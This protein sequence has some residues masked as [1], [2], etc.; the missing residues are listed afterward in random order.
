LHLAKAQV[1]RHPP[2]CKTSCTTRRHYHQ[3]IKPFTVADATPEIVNA[4]GGIN[5]ATGNKVKNS[6][7]H[8][9]FMVPNPHTTSPGVLSQGNMGFSSMVRRY[10]SPRK[11]I[12]S[13]FSKAIT[14]KASNPK[15]QSG[16]VLSP[17]PA[18]MLDTTKLAECDEIIKKNP[19]DY[20]SHNKKGILLHSL[21]SFNEAI[22]CFDEAITLAPSRPEPYINKATSLRDLGQFQLSVQCFDEALKIKFSNQHVV[23]YTKGTVLSLIGKYDEA[24]ICYDKVLQEVPNHP[25]AIYHRGICFLNLKKCKEG[26]EDFNATLQID[27]NNELAV[28][29]KGICLD[30]LDDHKAAIK[31]FDDIIEKKQAN[32]VHFDALFQKAKSLRKLNNNEE[33]LQCVDA[34]LSRSIP[35][36]QAYHLKALIL[37]DMGTYN[38]ALKCINFWLNDHPRDSRALFI[39]ALILQKA[40][41]ENSKEYKETL[42]KM[43]ELKGHAKK[44]KN[45]L[46]RLT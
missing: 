42:K 2:R 46:Q 13:M 5:A 33:A 11:P 6:C 15:S 19:K 40:E 3:S 28:L 20:V 18:N 10:I 39:K 24:V 29:N 25:N 21:G 27:P 16:R 22:N 38:P 7:V 43:L 9:G 32:K 31:C 41:G 30:S 36:G 23:H 4:E 1:A 14:Q 37:C 44:R 35:Y 8:R 17:R 12:V 34:I 45:L 26:L